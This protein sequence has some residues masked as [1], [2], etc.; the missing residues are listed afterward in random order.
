MRS[1]TMSA[2]ERVQCAINLEKPDR[3]PIWPDVTTSAAAAL[4]GQKN[5]EAV[6]QSFD[7][8]QDLELRFFDEY[9]SFCRE[10]DF[11]LGCP[12]G[13]LAQEMGDLNDSF[14]RK[15]EAAFGAMRGLIATCLAEAQHEGAISPSL[16]P[17]ETEDSKVV[18]QLSMMNLL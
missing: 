18:H 9:G 2:F 8:Q 1:E 12:L 5:W 14:S 3:V 16:H 10:Q 6:H 17:T 7:A 4:T 11:S 13:N 15:I